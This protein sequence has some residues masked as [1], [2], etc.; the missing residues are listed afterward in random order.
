MSELSLRENIFQTVREI[1]VQRAFNSNKAPQGFGIQYSG[2]VYDYE[3]INAMIN[4]ILDG[5]FGVGKNTN[6]FEA[7]L[8]KLI[9]AKKATMTNSGS[10]A[11]LLSVSAI[12]RQGCCDGELR[13][14]DEVI[15]PALAFP[16]TINPILQNNLVPV[17]LDADLGT[18]NMSTECLTDAL[19]IRTKAIVLCHALGNPNDMNF[20]LEFAKD[21]NLLI[22]EDTCDA[23]GSKYAGRYVGSF[24]DLATFSFYPAHHITTGEGGC[25][26]TSNEK[27]A[28][29]VRSMRD[30]GR[31]CEMNVCYPLSC[32][33]KSCPRSSNY[34]KRYNLLGLPPD[35][36]LRYSYTNIGYNFEPTEIQAAM[37]IAQLKKLPQ[38]IKQ[39][40]KNFQLL[41]EFFK[42][43]EDFFI[44][45]KWSK[46][47]EPSWFAFPLTIREKAPF[48]RDDIVKWLIK[49]KI[50]TKVL[51][52]G[53]IIRHPAYV[54][55]NYRVAQ[56]LSNTDLVMHNS[57]FVGVY[58]GLNENHMAYMCTVFKEFLN[59]FKFPIIQTTP[60]RDLQL[61]KGSN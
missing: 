49:H 48:H 33:D 31:A 7:E 10:S 6:K 41:Y 5:R 15:T 39:R 17:F 56:K 25:V 18:Y 61:L 26:V 60:N 20:L 21:R 29:V 50:E 8:A 46:E 43:Y 2:A 24:G 45:P 35:Y 19:S 3:E 58:P 28:K 40:K 37:G 54:N 57:F 16:T 38:F 14:G 27:L 47:S 9:G 1:L 22:I 12:M 42:N 44:L 36:D 13:A 4:A 11:N 30:W 34:E 53:N 52:G 51:F 55:A 59:S 32:P 23:L